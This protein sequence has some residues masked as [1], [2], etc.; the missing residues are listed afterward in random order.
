MSLVKKALA[1]QSTTVSTSNKEQAQSNTPAQTHID[2]Q[3]EYTLF[4]AAITSDLAQLKAFGD[5]ADKLEYKAQA[6][7]KN[8]YLAFL[9]SYR[10][11]GESY[12]NKVLI[13]VF[14]WLVDLKRWDQALELFPLLLSQKQPLPKSFN[15]DNWI[16]FLVDELY[17]AVNVHLENESSKQDYADAAALLYRVIDLL[18]H[19]EWAGLEIAGGKLFSITAKIEKVRHNYGNVIAYGE[20]A[21]AIN[22]KAGVKTLIKETLKL[23][24]NE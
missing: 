18:K 19:Q 5:I 10:K 9:D 16:T 3:T 14:I 7:E 12:T 23:I 11:K 2:K 1:K 8:E 21:Q 22:E 15:R 17:D 4:E 20:R 13:W 6:I 24:N